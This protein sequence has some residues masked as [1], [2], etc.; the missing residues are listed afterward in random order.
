MKKEVINS[1]EKIFILTEEG[2][3][4]STLGL[5]V[6]ANDLESVFNVKDEL[7]FEQGAAINEKKLLLEL[8]QKNPDSFIVLST[9]TR[10]D[11]LP[12]KCF[13]DVFD[14][15]KEDNKKT[16]WQALCDRIN[17]KE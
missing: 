1:I 13:E 8:L 14:V 4:F 7:I 5:K 3:A 6:V 12:P 16:C 17:G 15:L 9:A 11:Y 2:K 10:I